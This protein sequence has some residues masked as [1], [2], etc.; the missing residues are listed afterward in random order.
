VTTA[1]GRGRLRVLRRHRQGPPPLP[2]PSPPPRRRRLI[3]SR[4][5][6]TRSSRPIRPKPH[7]RRLRRHARSAPGVFDGLRPRPSTLSTLLS[8]ECGSSL[9]E[10]EAASRRD[11]APPARLPRSRRPGPGRTGG[12]D[13]PRPRRTPPPPQWARTTA[14]AACRILGARSAGG[15]GGGGRRARA[16]PARLRLRPSPSRRRAGAARPIHRPAVIRLSRPNPLPRPLPP[17][18][19]RS[20]AATA[21][22]AAGPLRSPRRKRLGSSAASAALD[23]VEGLLGDSLLLSCISSS[24]LWACDRRIGRCQ[25]LASSVR[26]DPPQTLLRVT[27]TARNRQSDFRSDWQK[28]E[29]AHG[30]ESLVTVPKIRR[31]NS[32]NHDGIA[33][34]F[35]FR[36]IL[37]WTS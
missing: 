27:K 21:E 17:Y 32:I 7:Q 16:T 34:R 5:S 37:A 9:G 24:G 3:I 15:F 25:A 13:G 36:R 8:P 14:R 20:T 11:L 26:R 10:R 6:R 30:D 18:C 1:A 33:R 29:N 19:G 22:A 4:C 2:P 31:K 35:F 12:G 28:S 23:S